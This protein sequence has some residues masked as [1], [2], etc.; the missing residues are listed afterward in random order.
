LND[1]YFD[2]LT[3]RDWPKMNAMVRETDD[4]SRRRKF[5]VRER[6]LK[7]SHYVSFVRILYIS[8]R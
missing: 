7:Y 3:E 5:D 4:F 6:R 2:I 8:E 1:R